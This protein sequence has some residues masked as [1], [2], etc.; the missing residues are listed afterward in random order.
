MDR[1]ARVF[2]GD[3]RRR[4]GRESTWWP[5]VRDVPSLWSGDLGVAGTVVGLGRVAH[6]RAYGIPVFLRVNP[7]FGL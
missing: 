7:S 1:G 4:G 5:R 6:I 2:H 3:V